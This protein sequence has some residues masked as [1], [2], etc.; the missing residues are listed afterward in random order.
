MT[1]HIPIDLC[2]RTLV[3][4]FG[5]P[6]YVYDAGR[7]RQN[8]EQYK[9][10]PYDN[11]AIHFASMCNNN[12]NILGLMKVLGINVFVNSPKHLLIAYRSGFLPEQI[13][14]TGTNLSDGDFEYII[15]D[16]LMVNVDSIGQLDRYGRLNP[17]SKVGL[18]INPTTSLLSS[19][20]S[21]GAFIGPNSRIGILEE[22]LPEAFAMA[23]KH[24]LILNGV[25]VYLGTNLMD[26]DSFRRSAAEVLRIANAFPELEYVD[27]GGGFG[28]KSHFQDAAFDVDAYGEMIA[29]K[30]YRFCETRGK[31]I[32]LI[33]EPG[34]A[35][36]ADA[37]Y[38]LTTVVDVKDRPDRVYVGVD[39]SVDIF[40]RP[41]FY[42][43]AYHEIA[44][45][46]ANGN[47]PLD[48][49]ADIC[50]NTTYSRDFLGRNRFLPRISVGDI[51]VVHTAGGY[52]Y[53]AI[54][55]FLG[56][57]K[58][59]EVLIDEGVA[60]LINPKETLPNRSRVCAL[61]PERDRQR[62][63]SP[64]ILSASY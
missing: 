10:I 28:V 48:K 12:P 46:D 56:R 31:K 5:S 18:R 4:R 16:N 41:L 53:S 20:D 36:V 27:F 54:T 21:N 1:S 43:D 62:I 13:I 40:P 35:L 8:V 9:R 7:I 30:M 29:G 37:G 42:E 44:V 51:L 3:E 14:F 25:H 15:T 11:A 58:P 63:D 38:F 23:R 57:L 22:E 26:L 64:N 61:S 52:C 59:A 33:L 50:G 19:R 49:P 2:A 45:Y 6:L 39:A 60:T 34:R 24:G 55:D 47:A 17:A 32:K